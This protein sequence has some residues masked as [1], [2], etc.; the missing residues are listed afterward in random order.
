MAN[1]YGVM[2]I[3][4]VILVDKEGKVVNLNA[5][6]EELASE[7]ERLLGPAEAKTAPAS[8]AP[9]EKGGSQE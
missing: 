1:Y 8:E 6:G 2:A 5:R 4:T 9:K 7:L 3:P